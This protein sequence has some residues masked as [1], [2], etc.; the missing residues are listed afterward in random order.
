MISGSAPGRTEITVTV[1]NSTSGNR[2]TPIFWKAL[3]PK[4]RTAAVNSKVVTGL[5]MAVFERIIDLVLRER[6]AFRSDSV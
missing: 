5:W 4:K 2:S 6:T 3:Y 1:G